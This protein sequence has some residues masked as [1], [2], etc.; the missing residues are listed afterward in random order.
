MLVDMAKNKL[1]GVALAIGD[2]AND[3]SMIQSSNVGVGIQGQEGS[4]AALSA[5][6][7]LHRFRHLKRL[8]LLHGRFN[9]YRTAKVVVFSFYK[10]IVFIFPVGYMAFWNL[11]STQQL[12][13]G[14][15]MS[16]F[17]VFWASLPPFAIGLWEMDI[18][19]EACLEHPVAFK[20]FVENP[21]FNLRM[22]TGWMLLAIYHSLVVFF[23]CYLNVVGNSGLWLGNGW[24]G[25]MYSWG[26]QGFWYTVSVVNFKMLAGTTNYTWPIIVSGLIGPVTWILCGLFYS[27]FAQFELN[28]YGTIWY[29]TQSYHFYM[30]FPMV[31]FVCVMP[32]V[33]YSWYV[34]ETSADLRTILY[35]AYIHGYAEGKSTKEVIEEYQRRGSKSAAG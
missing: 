33:V 25:D 13:E 3:V 30:T 23:I 24:S 26:N 10:N 12:Y 34:R 9:F 35:E 4:Q 17:N 11:G 19:M 6:F 21:W 7:V 1:D 16:V 28:Y 29:I 20:E 31:L 27:S 22:F 8:L 32:S 14:G 18:P 5:D 15:M 2:G